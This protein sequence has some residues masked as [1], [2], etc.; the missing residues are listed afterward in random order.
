VVLARVWARVMGS[1]PRKLI[2]GWALAPVWVGWDVGWEMGCTRKAL[3]GHSRGGETEKSLV[4]KR[5][6]AR[7]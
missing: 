6:A 1:R 3:T 4:V 7:V 2:T 5:S